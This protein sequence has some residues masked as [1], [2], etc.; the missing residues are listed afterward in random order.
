MAYT[1]GFKRTNA[2]MEPEPSTKGQATAEADALIKANYEILQLSGD[3]EALDTY[4]RNIRLNEYMGRL[5]TLVNE[6]LPDTQP[7]NKFWEDRV[8][9]YADESTAGFVPT[10]YIGGGKK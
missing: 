7:M 5:K 8:R 10:N 3:P 1:S 6:T 9:K 2:Y 4:R